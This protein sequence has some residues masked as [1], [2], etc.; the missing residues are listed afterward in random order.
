ML[1]CLTDEA[2]FPTQILEIKLAFFLS[3]I[4]QFLIL[5]ELK[6]QDDF[7]QAE[8]DVLGVFFISMFV[9]TTLVCIVLS[10]SLSQM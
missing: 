7:L 5:Q 1:S 8:A 4:F 3:E 9:Y 6:N 2:H 10:W